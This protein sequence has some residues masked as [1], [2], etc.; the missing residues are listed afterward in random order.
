MSHTVQVLV[1][2]ALRP[3]Q[4]GLNGGYLFVAPD[5]PDRHVDGVLIDQ[6]YVERVPRLLIAPGDI[7]E[8]SADDVVKAGRYPRVERCPRSG[9][10][11]VR[12]YVDKAIGTSDPL[13]P[14]YAVRIYDPRVFVDDPIE[15]TARWVERTYSMHVGSRRTYERDLALRVAGGVVIARAARPCGAGEENTLAIRA[16]AYEILPLAAAER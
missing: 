7:F 3:A 13:H 15:T 6:R 8:V 12:A 16:L 9:F 10:Q 2:G 1:D 11:V 14:E 4:S 5:G